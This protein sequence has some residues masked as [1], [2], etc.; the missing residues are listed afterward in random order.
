MDVSQAVD[1][2]A[3]LL[4]AK[5]LHQEVSKKRMSIFYVAASFQ[6]V[7]VPIYAHFITERIKASFIHSKVYNSMQ[8]K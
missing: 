7:N 3:A 8:R 2:V 1:M 5:P 4:I 6:H